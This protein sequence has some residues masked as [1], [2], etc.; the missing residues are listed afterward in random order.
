MQTVSSK[1]EG[2]SSKCSFQTLSNWKAM[3]SCWKSSL[4]TKNITSSFSPFRSCSFIMLCFMSPQSHTL[5]HM[6]F[7]ITTSASLSAFA[8]KEPSWSTGKGV[9]LLLC[10]HLLSSWSKKAGTADCS[11]LAEP[12]WSTET[13]WELKQ[14]CQKSKGSLLSAASLWTA[15]NTKTILL[16][17]TSTANHR[18]QGQ[19]QTL[20]SV[21]LAVPSSPQNG[22]RNR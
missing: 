22:Q 3:Q 21:C 14:L 1:G 2:G 17:S 15:H 4:A 5:P 6:L 16:C 10:T 9:C 7:L 18:L 13:A 20:C 19:L 12:K 11:E 8:A